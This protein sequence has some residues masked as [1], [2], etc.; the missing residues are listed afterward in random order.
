[1]PGSKFSVALLPPGD[2]KETNFNPV[3]RIYD[4]FNIRSTD[5][6]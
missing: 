6:H 3:V 1:M 4:L 2:T 5:F